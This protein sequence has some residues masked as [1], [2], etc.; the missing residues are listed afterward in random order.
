MKKPPRDPEAPG[1]EPDETP[2]TRAGVSHRRPPIAADRAIARHLRAVSRRPAVTRILSRLPDAVVSFD[3][4]W[5]YVYMNRQA[6]LNHQQPASDFL[7]HIVWDLF[8]EGRDLHSFQHY[9]R[10]MESQEESVFEEYVP[11]LGRWFEQRLFPTEQG[12][13]VI[14]RDISEWREIQLER[15][16]LAAKLAELRTQA[17]DARP[18]AAPAPPDDADRSEGESCPLRTFATFFPKY[19]CRASL[20]EL[21]SEHTAFTTIVRD[22]GALSLEIQ[23]AD[24][25]GGPVVITVLW[26][27]A[28]DYAR[29]QTNPVRG[30]ILI[31]LEQY[32]DE[33]CIEKYEVVRRTT[34]T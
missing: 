30:E 22:A 3:R 14:A 27:S 12:L 7:G 17:E 19:G 34:R 18:S 33:I 15:S 2:K 25:P 23:Q 10:A 24:D 20:V 31:L 32:V 28:A 13:T 6:E 29:W 8:P 4:D 5:R 16:K 1:E 11:M 9:H 26:R 21:L